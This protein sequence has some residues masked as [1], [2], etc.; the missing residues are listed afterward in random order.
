MFLK[1]V[2]INTPAPWCAAY[3]NYVLQE[4]KVPHKMNGLAISCCPSTPQLI[5]DKGK[6]TE[7]QQPKSGDLFFWYRTG[8]GH[9]GFIK[10]WPEHGDYFTTVE[11]NVTR[12]DGK[13]GVAIKTRKKSNV[14]KIFA[15]SMLGS[16]EES[17]PIAD[18]VVV[19]DV[20]ENV[21]YPATEE[22]NKKS[23]PPY[24]I[25]LVVVLVVLWRMDYIKIKT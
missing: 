6:K 25:I 19:E 22:K 11:G 10:E 2:G 17:E 8:G 14:Q 9:T 18:S 4:S 5:F 16:A 7:W 23:T 12:P 1:S 15:A 3:V 21:N 24:A 20:V 13:Q